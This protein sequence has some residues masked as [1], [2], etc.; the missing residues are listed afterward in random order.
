MKNTEIREFICNRLH[1]CGCSDYSEVVKTLVGFLENINEG[2]GVSYCA[3]PGDYYLL[4][5]LLDRAGLIEHGSSCR[6]CWLTPEGEN[7]LV[8][9]QQTTP[10]AVE[11]A[12]WAWESEK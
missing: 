12:P 8:S 11:A 2:K 7:F 1:V 9:L 5:G 10:E 4:T 3:R 6:F